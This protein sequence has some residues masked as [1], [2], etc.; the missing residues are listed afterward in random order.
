[1]QFEGCKYVFATSGPKTFDCSGFTLNVYAHFGIKFAHSARLQ[2]QYTGA[3]K[4]TSWRDL[5]AGDMVFF[6]STS[7]D[8]V[9]HCGIY[10][11]N[12]K[13]VHASSGKGEVVVSDFNSSSHYREWF[14]WGRKMV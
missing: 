6:R 7:T 5:E 3:D 8:G 11:G 13:F 2:S 9:G 14:M 10:I 12:G 4:V 1:M